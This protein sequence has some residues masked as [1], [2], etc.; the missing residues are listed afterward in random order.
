MT[1]NHVGQWANWLGTMYVISCIKNIVQNII[2]IFQCSAVFQYVGLRMWHFLYH[3]DKSSTR[4][5]KP[6]GKCPASQCK[7]IMQY[8]GRTCVLFLPC[9]MCGLV[10]CQ[11]QKAVKVLRR[12]TVKI[13]DASLLHAIV[14]TYRNKCNC[15]CGYSMLVTPPSRVDL[16]WRTFF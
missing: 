10:S 9:L 15:L 6:C 5:Q 16:D 8:Y 12:L 7:E 3:A 13:E 11:Q 1:C 14:R 4:S 2:I